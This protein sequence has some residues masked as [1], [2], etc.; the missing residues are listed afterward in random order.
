MALVVLVWDFI[1]GMIV[2]ILVVIISIIAVIFVL[3][4]R[5]MFCIP[6]VVFWLSFLEFRFVIFIGLIRVDVILRDRYVR[7]VLRGTVC[8]DVSP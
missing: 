3:L 2:R 6:C 7:I 5:S 8:F 4:F 1:V